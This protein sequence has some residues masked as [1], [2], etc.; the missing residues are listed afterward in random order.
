MQI[1][2]FQAEKFEACLPNTI[3]DVLFYYSWWKTGVPP[4]LLFQV[5]LFVHFL[6]LWFPSSEQ[7]QV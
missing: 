3:W 2:S 5:W 1:V 6:C 4:L 7:Y